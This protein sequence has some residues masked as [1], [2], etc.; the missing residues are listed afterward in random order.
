MKHADRTALESLA[1]LLAQVRERVPPLKEPGAGRFYL[2]SVA[3]LHFHHDPAGLFADLK[4]NG[5]WQRYPVNSAAD[6][7]ILLEA[8]DQQLPSSR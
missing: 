4:V 2:K 7:R 5:A 3:F 1:P 8:L 6:Y